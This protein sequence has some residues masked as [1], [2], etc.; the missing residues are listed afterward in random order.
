MCL[1]CGVNGGGS[2]VVIGP[3][4]AEKDER[5]FVR[6]SGEASSRSP[7]WLAVRR[8][9]AKVRFIP[10]LEWQEILS[11][12]VAMIDKVLSRGAVRGPPTNETDA[13]SSLKGKKRWLTHMHNGRI[14]PQDVNVMMQS[15]N[16]PPAL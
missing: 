4:K 8:D 11:A 3:L 5:W 13:C 1:K 12:R 7:H 16:H 9:Y 14:D 10:S 15:H 6:K 2:A